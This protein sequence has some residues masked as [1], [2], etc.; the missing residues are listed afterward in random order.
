MGLRGKI[1][2]ALAGT[3]VLVAAVVGVLVHVRTSAVQLDA[4]R[5]ALDERFVSLL[6][7]HVEGQDAGLVTE[8]VPGP[9]V[10][11]V[12]SA[13]VRATYLDGG[14]L[15]AASSVGDEVVGL[16]RPYA[17]EREALAS[18]D[19]V[20]VG[21]GVVAALV[22][23]VAGVAVAVRLTRRI[24]TLAST[25]SAIA[26]GDLTARVFPRETPAKGDGGSSGPLSRSP[27]TQGAQ[28]SRR[29]RDSDAEGV[30]GDPGVRGFPRKR[31][32]GTAEP[33][34]SH[35]PTSAGDRPSWNSSGS[36]PR[37]NHPGNAPPRSKRG[38]EVM[39]VGIALDRMADVLQARLEAEQR[40]TADIAH[41]LRTPVAGLV[42]AASLLPP[43]RPAELVR[44]RAAV[45]RKLVEDVLEVARL[46]TQGEEAAFEERE[47]SALARR[48][49]RDTGAL[50]V[51]ERDVVVR[52]DPRRLERVLVNLVAN[53]LLHGA[54]PVTVTVD[55]AVVT[56]ADHGSG[57]PEGLLAWG[58]R[59]FASGAAARGVGVGLGLT[60]AAGQARVLGADLEFANSEDGAIATLRLP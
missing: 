42:T 13:R 57:F 53:A 40:V 15:W 60:I 33:G 34:D 38:D 7:Q 18:L 44:D 49:I 12:S 37:R 56:V 50:L 47:L 3:A 58:P 45:L 19:R 17:A 41:E 30:V 2:L 52:T 43:G 20:L 31:L 25:A 14:T 39:A 28:P 27:S 54:E 5:T 9:L 6:A 36:P 48:A 22:A 10:K 1:A 35:P 24:R 11:A 21:S 26:G 29:A 4:A 16:S 23:S 59:R 55:G 51:V 46:D 32:G 8:G